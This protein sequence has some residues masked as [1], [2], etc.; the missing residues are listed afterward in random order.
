MLLPYS[1]LPGFLHALSLGIFIFRIQ[2]PVVFTPSGIDK[3][4]TLLFFKVLKVVRVIQQ[5][6]NLINGFCRS[7]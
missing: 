5:T 1:Q 3:G 2:Q 6:K 4:G 7:R